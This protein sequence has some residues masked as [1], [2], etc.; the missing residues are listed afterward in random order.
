M[1]LR[2]GLMDA[3]SSPRLR[4]GSWSDGWRNNE[5]RLEH[6]GRTSCVTW[7][8]LGPAG[9]QCVAGQ[10]HERANA[11]GGARRNSNCRG[12]RWARVGESETEKCSLMNSRGLV[13]QASA[14]GFWSLQWRTPQAEACATKPSGTN[15]VSIPRAFVWIWRNRLVR[16]A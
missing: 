2:T 16:N 1:G 13:A 4:R 3:P 7:Q 9:N 8:H 5:N 12:D 14:C 15:W 6:R 11:L 10:F